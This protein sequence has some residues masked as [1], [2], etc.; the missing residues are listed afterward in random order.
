MCVQ[1]QWVCLKQFWILVSDS[2]EYNLE[3]GKEK[4]KLKKKSHLH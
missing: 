4:K 1:T 2:L 3:G